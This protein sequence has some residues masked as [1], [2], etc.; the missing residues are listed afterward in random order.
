MV[1]KSESATNLTD[2]NSSQANLDSKHKVLRKL[3]IKLGQA[4]QSILQYALKQLIQVADPANL[5]IAISEVERVLGEDDICDKP[6]EYSVQVLHEIVEYDDEPDLETEGL[7]SYIIMTLDAYLKRRKNIFAILAKDETNQEEIEE[8]NQQY[9]DE[10]DNLINNYDPAIFVQEPANQQQDEVQSPGQQSPPKLEQQISAQT[11]VY[12]HAIN[13]TAPLEVDL[14]NDFNETMTHLI[15]SLISKNNSKIHVPISRQTSQNTEH[16]DISPGLLK[17]TS[18]RGL[19]N[20]PG[21]NDIKEQS[22]EASMMGQ[23][24]S[25]AT[26][27]GDLGQEQQDQDEFTKPMGQLSAT[28]LENP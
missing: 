20:V 7:I 4:G 26:F 22:E 11:E 15:P 2:T 19:L 16:Q 25:S 18:Q 3:V 24:K 13:S 14:D 28:K 27:G 21:V 5:Q 12:P 6:V 9:F 23:S 10:Y 1:S 8:F 17:I